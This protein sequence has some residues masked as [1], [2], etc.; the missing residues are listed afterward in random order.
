L[1]AVV[2]VYVRD[3]ERDDPALLPELRAAVEL[4]RR[5]ETKGGA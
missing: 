5:F 3:D 1:R 2:A 4:L